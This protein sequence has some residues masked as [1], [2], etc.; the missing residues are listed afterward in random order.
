MSAV[1]DI[2]DYCRDFYRQEEYPALL[3]QYTNWSSVK[4]LSGL[5]ILDATPLFANTLLKYVP[6]LAAGAELTAATHDSIPFDPAMPDLLRQWGIPRSHNTAGGSFDCIL[7]CGGVHSHLTPAYGTAEL[8]RS[9]FYRYRKAA[10]PVIMVDDSRI[11][12]I[13]TCLGTGDGFLRGMRHAGFGD[14]AGRKIVVFGCGK[15]GKGIAWYAAGEGALVSAVDEPGTPVPENVQFISR[16]DRDAVL[17]AVRSA[18]CVVTATGIAG[19]MTGS[20]AA[21]EI[22]RGNQIVAAMGIE[23]EWGTE[24]PP[25][26]VLNGNMPLNFILSEPTR[27]RYIDP[28]MALSNAAALDLVQRRYPPGIRPADADTGLFYWEI[29]ER[30]SLI[31]SEIDRLKI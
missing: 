22:M 29:M 11:K 25:E 9:G 23:N 20:G 8:T 18:W 28:T 2:L 13:E 31:A 30:S 17:D 10:Y 24:L 14:M 12:T 26:R 1:E 3:C 15:V 21:Q 5:R 27:L 4:P 7:D 6:L 19:A 16:H